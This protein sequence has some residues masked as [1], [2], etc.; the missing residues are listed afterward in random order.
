MFEKRSP[1]G[2]A[3]T[4]FQTTHA[5]TYTRHTPTLAHCTQDGCTARMFE[6]KVAGNGA[7]SVRIDVGSVSVDVAEVSNK[8]S[9]DAPA[10]AVM[11]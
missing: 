6:N 7:G 1:V 9:L 8:N 3:L 5:H 4:T 2:L 11:L 10:A